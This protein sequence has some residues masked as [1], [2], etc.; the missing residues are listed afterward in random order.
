MKINVNLQ[1]LNNWGT[2]ICLFGN[3]LTEQL[4][5][6]KKNHLYG[7]FNF[8]RG[9]KPSDLERFAFPV[10]YST[11]PYKLVYSKLYR[12]ALPFY[13]H[14]MMGNKADVNLFFTYRIPRVKYK[15]ILIS[16]IHDLIPL[17]VPQENKQIEIDYRDDITYTINNSDYL[18]TVSE[19]SK[20]DIVAEFSYPIDKIFVVPNGV[21]YVFFNKKVEDDTLTLVRAKYKL[22]KKFILYFGNIRRHKNVVSLIRAYALLSTEIRNEISLVITRGNEDLF[23]LVKE[24]KLEEEVY[25]TSFI[26]DEDIPALYKLA[27]VKVFISLYEGFGLPVI[28]AMAAGVPVITSNISSLPEVA[29]GA[30]ILVNPLEIVEISRAIEDVITNSNL[31]DQMIRLGYDNAQKFSWEKSGEKLASILAQLVK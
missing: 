25:F 12:S 30:A 14:S 28:E 11:I 5:L 19:A 17:K 15:G 24:L 2:G 1:P 7:C 21:D 16:T 4:F 29:G 10:K 26:D 8:V 22:P 6:N 9:V 13:Y 18:I 23:Q 27:L 20:K 31:R 3:K